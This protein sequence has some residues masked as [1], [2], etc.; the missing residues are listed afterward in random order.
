M[1]KQRGSVEQMTLYRVRTNTDLTEGR[2]AER[3]LGWFID[4][5]IALKAAKGNYVMGSDCPVESR[6]ELVVRM[7]SGEIFL[8]GER[9]EITYEDPREIK[10]RALAKLTPEEVKVWFPSEQK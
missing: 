6:R 4:N 5:A 3:T 7:E 2:G 1:S 10:A 9:V 8:L